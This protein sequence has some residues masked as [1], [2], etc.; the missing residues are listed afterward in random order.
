MI[1]M[2]IFDL[3]KLVENLLV[4]FRRNSRAG[5]GDADL[6]A[7]VVVN[8]RGERDAALT[9]EFDG[10]ADQVAEDAREL[11]AIRANQKRWRRI[12]TDKFQPLV[13]GLLGELA[14]LILKQV[15]KR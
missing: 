3:E 12:M 10:V 4:M 8:V 13:L 14:A 9:G 6:Q 2:G 1:A 7:A 15:T 11:Y 5:V